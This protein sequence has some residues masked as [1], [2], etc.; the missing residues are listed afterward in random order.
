MRHRRRRRDGGA[1][2]R[3]GRGGEKE[4]HEDRGRLRRG[5]EHPIEGG[6]FKA[7]IEWRAQL[8]FSNLDLGNEDI[9]TILSSRLDNITVGVNWHWNPMTHLMWNVIR[10]DLDEVGDIWAFTWRGQIEF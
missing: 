4:R 9:E 7:H 8:R 3:R 10:S 1:S 2:A 5:P 6:N